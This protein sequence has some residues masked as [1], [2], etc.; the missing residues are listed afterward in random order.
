MYNYRNVNIHMK[1]NSTLLLLKTQFYL[2]NHLI[3]SLYFLGTVEG[4]EK[5][6]N[7]FECKWSSLQYII[8]QCC[9]SEW[10][11][12]L[13]NFSIRGKIL[14]FL[15]HIKV[16]CLKFYHIKIFNFNFGWD[17]F[18]KFIT[19]LG[20]FSAFSLK[21]YIRKIIATIWW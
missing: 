2:K 15:K 14:Q 20:S 12:V 3:I 16:F 6:N 9:E 8:A 13:L 18:M 19:K 21:I 1:T 10:R 7:T 5:A 4:G 17:F 11:Q